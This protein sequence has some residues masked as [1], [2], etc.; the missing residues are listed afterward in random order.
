[1]T[2][3]TGETDAQ[4]TRRMREK[5]KDS[6]ARLNMGY[7]K[8]ELLLDKFLEKEL[9]LDK[10]DRPTLLKLSEILRLN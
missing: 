5:H 1:M 4:Y 3:L 6:I 9:E 7:T 8:E 2:I 10:K